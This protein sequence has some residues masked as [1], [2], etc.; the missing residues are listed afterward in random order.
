[1]DCGKLL[2]LGLVW[3]LGEVTPAFILHFTT[4]R[5]CE[6]QLKG[7]RGLRED[8]CIEKGSNART[9]CE[10]IYIWERERKNFVPAASGKTL[11]PLRNDFDALRGKTVRVIADNVRL[12]AHKSIECFI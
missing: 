6:F 5:W 11:L 7:T 2:V 8:I 3:C 10:N 4:F 1:M 12:T 9:A